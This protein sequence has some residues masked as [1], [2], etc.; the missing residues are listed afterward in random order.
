VGIVKKAGLLTDFVAKRGD[1]AST[2][3]K[4]ERPRA[5]AK[6]RSEAHTRR[7][8]SKVLLVQTATD[9]P[10]KRATY[11]FRR[12]QITNFKMLAAQQ[13]RDVSEVVRD[14]ADTYLREH[15]R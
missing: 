2:K 9:E 6:R 5:R 1:N 7:Q 4:E 12:D 15:V 3:P 14:I 11:Y 10:L 8:Q 13:G